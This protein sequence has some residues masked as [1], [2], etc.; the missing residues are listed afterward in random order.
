M[1]I[2]N[3]GHDQGNLRHLHTWKENRAMKIT[4]RAK[5]R[6]NQ[7]YSR[8]DTSG[9]FYSNP[10]QRDSGV[11]FIETAVSPSAARI[12]QFATARDVL[13]LRSE[14]LGRGEAVPAQPGRAA[15]TRNGRCPANLLNPG[16][17]H[18]YFTT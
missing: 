10:G 5:N 11:P 8:W 18:R 9:S 2:M 6:F 12:G 17:F 16:D 1:V 14:S 3:Q 4:L 13:L 15:W 7:A